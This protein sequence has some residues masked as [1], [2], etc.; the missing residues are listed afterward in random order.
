VSHPGE[1]FDAIVMNTTFHWRN[2]AT[3]L[4][5]REFLGIA[6]AHLNPDGILL[7]NVTGSDDVMA[8]GLAVFR[9]GFRFTSALVVSDA[10]IVFDRERWKRTL[11]RYSID[12]KP[13]VNQGDPQQRQRLE[14]IVNIP[15]DPEGS[16]L[17]SVEDDQQLRSRLQHRTI[18]TDD[19]MATEW[20]RE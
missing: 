6:R 16:Q 20:R 12:G 1:R 4:L 2:H 3:N 15:D 18:I 8:T 19:N 9:Y 7:Y 11:L 13:V 5:S 10:P 17:I 14:E